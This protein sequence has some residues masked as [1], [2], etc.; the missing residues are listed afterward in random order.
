MLLVAT[1]H[2]S[3]FQGKEREAEPQENE[4]DGEA[5]ERTIEDEETHA[6]LSA[7]RKKVK[8][9]EIVSIRRSEFS[10]TQC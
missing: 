5:G 1:D 6:E 10:L 4:E 9:Q 8:E 7:L 2:D 3:P